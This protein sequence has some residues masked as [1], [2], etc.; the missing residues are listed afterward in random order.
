MVYS[1]SGAS[2]LSHRA[3]TEIELDLMYRVANDE[4]LDIAWPWAGT[5]ETPGTDPIGGR[6]PR[7]THHQCGCRP[8]GDELT[9][10]SRSR[11]IEAACAL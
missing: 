10:S 6:A 1:T 9:A 11:T 7:N 2:R 4:P 3:C 5:T 8:T